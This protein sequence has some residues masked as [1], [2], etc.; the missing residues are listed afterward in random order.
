[1]YRWGN[2]RTYRSGDE[3]DQRL[4]FAHDAHWIDDHL[5][6]DHPQFGKIAVFNNKFQPDYSAGSIIDNVFDTSTWSFPMDQR[7]WVPEELENIILHPDTFPLFSVSVS[8]M[9]VLSN[10][11]T[12]LFA[13]RTGHAF[14]ITSSGKVS[15]DYLIPL[16]AGRPVS[17]GDTLQVNDNFSFRFKRYPLDYPAFMD[18]DLTALDPIELNAPANFCELL[19]PTSSVSIPELLIFPNPATTDLILRN[20]DRSVIDAEI[21]DLLGMSVE[22]RLLPGDQQIFDLFGFRPGIIY[23]K[24]HQRI[25]KV[26]KI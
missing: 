26:V 2:P 7:I 15:W 3:S 17:Q 23:V 11:N 1:M 12:L 20:N 5:D 10:G 19:T 24:I 18:R 4:F 8:S 9:Q 14:E 22:A 16:R 6:E 21:F 25:F 13:G